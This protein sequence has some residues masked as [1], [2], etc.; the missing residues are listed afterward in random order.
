[1]PIKEWWRGAIIYQIYPR[2]FYDSNGDGVGDLPGITAKLDYVASLGVDA[3]WLSP[4]FKS[5]MKDFGYDVA[6]YR[7]VDPLFGTLADFK[8]LLQ[9]AHDLGLKVIID[10]VMSHTSNEH[11]WFQVSR[12]NR[13]NPKANWYVWADAKP[14]GSPPNNWQSIFGGSSWEFDMHRG[15]Y[16]L[17]NFLREQPDLNLHNPEVQEAI[18]AEAAF[19][20]DMGVDGFRLDALN[21]GMHNRA[22]TDNPP[23]PFPTPAF[24]NVNFATPHTMQQHVNDLSQPEMFGFLEKIRALLDKYDGDRMAVAEV[25]GEHCIE[26][27]AQYTANDKLLHTAYNFSLLSGRQPSATFIHNAVNIFEQQPGEPWPSWALSN[28]DVVRAVSRW[29]NEHEKDPRFAKLLTA[30]LFSLRG[31]AFLYQGEELGLPEADIEFEDIQDPWGLYLYPQWQG[32]DGARTPMPWD[33]SKQHA[34]FSTADKTWLP[35]SKKHYGLAVTTQEQDPAATLHFVRNFLPWRRNQPALLRGTMEFLP[36]T[37]DH[38]L[39]FI[40]ALGNEKLL[41]LFNLSD[42][43][44]SIEI[45]ANA[46]ANIFD[47]NHQSGTITGNK[48]HLPPYGMAYCFLD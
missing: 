15:Q 11:K 33:D 21:Y 25:G 17:H 24:H 46:G 9:K 37:D 45:P 12:E 20:L 35:V 30:L 41:C 26:V 5:P 32:R 48:A 27:A 31:S 4:F 23:N 22:L 10:Q 36:V 34:G 42:Q 8:A 38:L 44:K 40:R 1:M 28:H 29:G 18:L 3:I 39:G 47:A 16:Y 7:D 2:S 43:D 14:D 19:W 13:T 6:D